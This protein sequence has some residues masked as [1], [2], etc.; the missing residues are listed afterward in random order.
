MES[1]LSLQ[2]V[3]SNYSIFNTVNIDGKDY[4]L[5]DEMKINLSFNDIEQE[6]GSKVVSLV[7]KEKNSEQTHY[8]EVLKGDNYGILSTSHGKTRDL[9][10]RENEKVNVQ[11]GEDKKKEKCLA[12]VNGVKRL[13]LINLSYDIPV[14]INGKYMTENLI[15]LSVDKSIQVSMIDL[16]QGFL[17]YKKIDKSPH[18]FYDFYQK[19]FQRL[20]EF[21]SLFKKHLDSEGIYDD[22]VTQK[23]KELQEIEDLL[24]INFNLPKVILKK[25]YNDEMYFEFISLCSLFHV[26]NE[27]LLKKKPIKIVKQIYELFF[28]QKA[29]IQKDPQLENYQKISIIIELGINIGECE[30]AEQFKQYNF[31]YYPT[32]NFQ[33]DS[34]GYSAMKFLQEFVED[35][36]EKSPF[37]F[38]LFLI[39]SGKFIYQG[40]SIYGYGLLN[41]NMLISHLKDILPEVI[42]TYYDEEDEEG[43]TNKR[44]GCVTVNLALIFKSIGEV[45]IH[46]PIKDKRSR[47]NNALKM[48]I[49]LFHELFGH[50]K[51]GS[52]SEI[53]SPNRFF[54]EEGKKLLVL[55]QRNSY[56]EGE[57][58]IKILRN[59][60]LNHDSGHFLEYFFGKCRSGYIIDLLDILLFY[61]VNMSFLYNKELFNKNIDILRRYIELKYLVFKE[62]KILLNSIKSQT[63][64][65]E[66]LTLEKIV[67]DN[68]IVVS[69]EKDN[70]PNLPPKLLQKNNKKFLKE[71]EKSIQVD[72]NYYAHKSSEEIRKKMGEKNISPELRRMLMHLLLSRIRKK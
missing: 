60:R 4:K 23:M 1:T 21:H 56:E 58:I 15:D 46:K 72:Y 66:I 42:Y 52:N 12:S 39:D 65:E 44:T 53:N 9:I 30:D 63:I 17:P 29:L 3:N 16:K 13:L 7:I 19:N 37:Y 59:D 36:N 57:N 14:Y 38:P 34:I 28:E 35:L 25:N 11:I 51:T 2:I 64:D 40:E 43:S 49:I 22:E 32:K 33:L 5:Q 48:F 67:N 47:E 70:E 41:K 71:K 10:F 55:R 69:I 54:D 62:K 18:K 45:N 26:L 27:I 68:K 31:S 20:K 50:K 8:F 6:Y 24:F 61:D